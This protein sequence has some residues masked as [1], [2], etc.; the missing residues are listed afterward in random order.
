MQNLLNRGISCRRGIMAIRRELPY[1][2]E[3]WDHR[4]PVTN[5]VTDTAV[6]LPLFHHMQ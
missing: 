3:Q 2:Q 1:R 5:R 4:L 6:L